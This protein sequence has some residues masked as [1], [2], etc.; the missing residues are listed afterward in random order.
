[1]DHPLRIHRTA[2]KLSAEAL[3]DRVGVT[4]S[5]I[6]RIETWTQDPSLS[7]IRSLCD[8]FPGLT[9]NDFMKQA[10]EAQS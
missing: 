1:M 4:K 6:S 3:A 5:T 7:L 2:A 8:V 9:A 10:V